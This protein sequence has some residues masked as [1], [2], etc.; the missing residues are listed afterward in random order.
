MTKLLTQL[1]GLLA[2]VFLLFTIT[3]PAL[4]EGIIAIMN[5]DLGQHR[6]SGCPSRWCACYLDRV[7]DE[8]GYKTQGSYRARDYAQYGKPAKPMSEG[9][10]MVMKHHV[11]IVA[12]KCDDGRVRL[13]S[14]NHSK[15]VGIGCYSPKKAIAWRKP[16]R[17]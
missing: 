5:D 15:K 1:R 10:I 8:A 13:I 6:P 7:L 12:G 17:S 11:G 9:S 4:S 14:G 3:G 16:V 2:A